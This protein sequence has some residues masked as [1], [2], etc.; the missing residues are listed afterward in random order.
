MPGRTGSRRW[1]I[2]LT[3][4][5]FVEKV[6]GMVR[7]GVYNKPEWLDIMRAIPPNN[8][9]VYSYPKWKKAP[10][11]QYPEDHL[12]KVRFQRRIRTD[13]RLSHLSYSSYYFN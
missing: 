9:G 6:V 5:P 12:Y 8:M 13:P 7:G 11:V 4:A 3:Q 2:A 10:K 1:K